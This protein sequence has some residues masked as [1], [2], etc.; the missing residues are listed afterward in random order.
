MSREAAASSTTHL[1][2]SRRDFGSLEQALDLGLAEVG[3]ADGL[4][5]ARLVDGL[6][7]LPGRLLDTV[8]VDN[9]ALAVFQGRELGVIPLRVHADWPVDEVQVDIVCPERL[10]RLVQVLLDAGVVRA[11]ELGLRRKSGRGHKRK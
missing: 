3:D 9:V 10:E 1:V 4:R 8:V 11:P 6:H 2:R 7:A 5:L